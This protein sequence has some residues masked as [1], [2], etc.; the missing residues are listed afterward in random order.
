KPLYYLPF[1]AS[2]QD[3]VGVVRGAGGRLLGPVPDGVAAVAHVGAA[4]HLVRGRYRDLRGVRCES[5][6]AGFERIE[7][8]SKGVAHRRRAKASRKN[9]RKNRMKHLLFCVVLAVA[10]DACGCGNK[11][12]GPVACDTYTGGVIGA[13]AL[14]GTYDLKSACLGMKPDQ[15]GARGTVTIAATTFTAS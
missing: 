10:A 13:G 14:P 15:P 11:V 7:A 1:A 4:H 3:A 8:S 5:L 6:Q 2:L 9:V 12:T